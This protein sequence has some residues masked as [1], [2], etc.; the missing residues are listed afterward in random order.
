VFFGLGGQFGWYKKQKDSEK[1]ISS[2]VED[3]LNNK[4]NYLSE[5]IR[6][7]KAEY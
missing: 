6:K 2:A 4:F 1:R 3:K 7:S 5:T